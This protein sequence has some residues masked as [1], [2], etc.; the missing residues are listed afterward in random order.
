MLHSLL[1]TECRAIDCLTK[2]DRRTKNDYRTKNDH[3][4]KNIRRTIDT[5]QFVFDI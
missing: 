4:I 3:R 2:N 1:F 5:T